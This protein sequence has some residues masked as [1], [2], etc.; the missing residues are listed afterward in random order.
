MGKPKARPA[1]K[2]AGI[3]KTPATRQVSS[4]ASHP[5][6]EGRMRLLIQGQEGPLER[7]QQAASSPQGQARALRQGRLGQVRSGGDNGASPLLQTPPPTAL[8]A[9]SPQP[10][11]PSA[12]DTRG[13]GPVRMTA[14][15]NTSPRALRAARRG[16]ELQPH[17]QRRGEPVGR[18]GIAAPEELAEDQEAGGDAATATAAV[19]NGATVTES[20]AVEVV[21]V[22]GPEGVAAEAT[23]AEVAV[24]S[25]GPDA[26]FGGGSASPSAIPQAWQPEEPGPAVALE[27]TKEVEL[28]ASPEPVTASVLVAA[29]TAAAGERDRAWAEEDAPTAAASAGTS[30]TTEGAS[31]QGH[32]RGG[33]DRRGHGPGGTAGA[34]RG[35]MK[36]RAQPAPRRPRAGLGP[37][38]LG[39]LLGWL[40][41]GQLPQ[42]QE[43]QW[44]SVGTSGGDME[45]GNGIRQTPTANTN[46]AGNAVAAKG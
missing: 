12:P 19:G 25:D 3:G 33:S 42:G 20:E 16:E 4:K 30:T 7:T 17:E 23:G 8:T 29:V 5:S 24:E 34:A 36:L 15:S 32:S 2:E 14:A 31:K 6:S 35:K 45:A 46:V 1:T 28:A 38:P 22:A 40:L 11:L 26:A 44:P 21:V 9:P 18:E 10:P 27:R 39:P 37:G 43:R 13:A 41:Q